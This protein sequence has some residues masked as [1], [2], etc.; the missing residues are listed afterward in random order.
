MKLEA[1]V[2][3]AAALKLLE[4]E[5]NLEVFDG[6]LSDKLEQTRK[7]MKR[8]IASHQDDLQIAR[9]CTKNL[10]NDMLEIQSYTAS[11]VNGALGLIAAGYQKVLPEPRYAVGE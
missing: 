2:G 11:T 4:N 1:M 5:M 9:D 7:R 3:R 8:P 10:L 6:I